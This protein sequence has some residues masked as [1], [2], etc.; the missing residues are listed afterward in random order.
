MPN[1][2]K[3][4]SCYYYGAWLTA[5]VATVGSLFFSEVMGFVPCSLCWYQRIFVYPIAV[6]LTLGV[7]RGDRQAVVYSFPLAALGWLFAFYHN[8]LMW[9]IIP[10]TASP[11]RSGIP[12][13][14]GYI[15]YFGFITIPLLSFVALSLLLILTFPKRESHEQ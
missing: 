9:G 4:L 3:K 2:T 13:S 5:L 15:E 12:C 6:L 7:Y 10:E 14:T 1:P 11:C 8:L